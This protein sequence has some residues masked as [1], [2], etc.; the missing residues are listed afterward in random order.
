MPSEKDDH[1]YEAKGSQNAPDPP[2]FASYPCEKQLC[3]EE[4]CVEDEAHE[5][6][7]AIEIKVLAR[8][9]VSLKEEVSAMRS[10]CALLS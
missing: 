1:E 4:A 7:G 10:S 3:T 6:H 9:I 8:H 5:G 2:S